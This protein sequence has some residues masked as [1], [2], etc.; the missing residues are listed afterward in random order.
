MKIRK[1]HDLSGIDDFLEFYDQLRCITEKLSFFILLLFNNLNEIFS[2]VQ[3]CFSWTSW[4]FFKLSRSL[5]FQFQV[6]RISCGE[7]K[8][9]PL[10]KPLSLISSFFQVELENLNI[11]IQNLIILHMF[12]C[13]FWRNSR[14]ST[15]IPQI[16]LIIRKCF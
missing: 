13:E 5:I 15:R 6:D 2:N 3:L 4:L 16:F 8:F 1:N 14:F 7:M 10:T 11:F 9:F 12:L